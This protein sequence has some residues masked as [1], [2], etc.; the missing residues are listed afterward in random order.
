MDELL[1]ELLG[2]LLDGIIPERLHTMLIT[3]VVAAA[4][5]ILVAF[6][7]YAVYL[8]IGSAFSRS[9]GWAA[10]GM[11]AA[12][13]FGYLCVFCYALTLSGIRTLRKSTR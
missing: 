3:G 5:V 2:S 4:G 1:H 12:V 9:F 10:V 13:F 7:L 6:G 11:L 8:A